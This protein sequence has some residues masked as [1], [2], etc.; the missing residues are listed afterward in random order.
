MRHR[1]DHRSRG[2]PGDLPADARRPGPARRGRGDPGP[3]SGLLAGTR[4]LRI[5]DRDRAV[6]PWTSADGRWLLCYNGEIFNYRELRARAD[7]PGAGL[8]TESD[9]EVVLEAFLAVGR[10]RGDPAARRVRLR[11]RRTGHRPGRTWPATR[12]GSSRSTGPVADGRLHVASEVKALVGRG[13]PI[14]EVPPGHHGW[15]RARSGH[16]RAEPVRRPAAPRRRPAGHRR[17]GRG[18]DARPA[19]RCSDASGCGSTPT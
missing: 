10:G 4:R 6:Q 1:V 3:T 12:S 9:T 8:R 14:A 15:A 18:R 13:A 19:P 2:R 5:V 17:P 11:D 7:P 16:A